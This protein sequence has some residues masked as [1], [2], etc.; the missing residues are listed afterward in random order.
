VGGPGSFLGNGYGAGGYGAPY[1]GG[2]YG[3]YAANQYGGSAYNAGGYAVTPP[4][5]ALGAPVAPAA[6][7]PGGIG[8]LTGSYLGSPG[9]TAPPRQPRII[10]NPYDNTILVQGTPQEW[11][12][13]KKLLE[14]IDIP[15]RQVLIEAKIYSVDLSGA[16]SAGVNAAFNAATA[17]K[18]QSNRFFPS[19][20]TTAVGTGGSAGLALTASALVGHNRQLLAFLTAQE[21][22]SKTKV[23]SAPSVI[24]TDSIQ[25]SINVGSSVPTLSSQAVGAGI[26][27]G[28]NSVFTNTVNNISTGTTL[29]I[30]ARVNPS[31]IVTLV[32]NQQVSDP[33]P[34]KTDAAIQSPSFSQKTVSTQVTVQD[35]DTVAIG[36]IIQETNAESS[37]GI[38]IL[39][40]LPYIGALFGT[41]S[42]SK[43]RSELVIFLTPRVIYDTNQVMEATQELKD[44]MKHLRKSYQE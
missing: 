5:T 18:G 17:A 34:P 29:S 39:H 6:A 9:V 43:D 44:Q 42:I 20:V 27:L 26:Q 4:R 37:S 25:A 19:L 11:E 16:F 22:S 36:G 15:P 21:T 2:G 40:K 24:A 13:I 35:G 30:L 41:K 38:P 31:G 7:P 14:Q 12:A 32:I 23:I 3:A 10:P 8:D 1:G 33:V 28:G